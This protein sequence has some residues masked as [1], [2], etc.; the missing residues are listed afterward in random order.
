MY[1]DKAKQPAEFV[2]PIEFVIPE[3]TALVWHTP[4]D[5][6]ERLTDTGVVAY[7]EQGRPIS[8]SGKN[9]HGQM[10]TLNL[11]PY[12]SIGELSGDEFNRC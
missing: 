9:G 1:A 8:W 6:V 3:K 10:I 11:G 12:K 2:I 7:D 5:V 4:P